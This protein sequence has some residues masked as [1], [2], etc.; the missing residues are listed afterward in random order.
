MRT[1]RISAAVLVAAGTL[2]SALASPAA[3]NPLDGSAP[4]LCAAMQV[5]ECDASGCER[6]TAADVNL[7]PFFV[8]DIKQKA[9]TAVGGDG[10]KT[11]IDYSEF[12]KGKLVLHGGQ[13]GRGWSIV[14]ASDTGKL[15][16]SV[17]DAEATFVV[18]GACILR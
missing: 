14:V 17:V 1:I 8:V 18:S 4:I 15:S 6:R 13:E 7:P 12:E 3:A 11:P 2:L 10:R 16:A 9:L 5:M